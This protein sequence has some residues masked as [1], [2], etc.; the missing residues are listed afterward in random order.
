[1]FAAVGYF[2]RK[3]ASDF[4]RSTIIARGEDKQ[5]DYSLG[6]ELALRAELEPARARESHR[7]P[8]QYF[9]LQLQPQRIFRGAAL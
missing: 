6:S 2:V 8:L 3:D 7:E 9:A 5:T 4:A 1:M